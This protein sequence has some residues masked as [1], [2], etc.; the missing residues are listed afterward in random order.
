MTVANKVRKQK[1]DIILLQ[2]H[3]SPYMIIP[4]LVAAVGTSASQLA[5]S[6]LCRDGYV[7]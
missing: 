2:H 6:Y 7:R 4:T 3:A 1:M 5:C